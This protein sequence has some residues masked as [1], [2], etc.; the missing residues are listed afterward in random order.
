[1]SLFTADICLGIVIKNFKVSLAWSRNG[2]HRLSCEV[3]IN[4]KVTLYAENHGNRHAGREFFYI[5][6]SNIYLWCQHRM[7][8]VASKATRKKLK[9]PWKERY[10]EA[11]KENLKF[12]HEL[13]KNKVNFWINPLLFEIHTSLCH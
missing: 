7:V 11:D 13:R 3:S 4:Q 12:I 10:S 6:E 5:A 9:G 1:M 8:K 2:R